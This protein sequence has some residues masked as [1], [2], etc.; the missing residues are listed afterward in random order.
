MNTNEILG[1]VQ[2]AVTSSDFTEPG[3]YLMPK[4]MQAFYTYLRN[5]RNPLLNQ[6]RMHKMV[7]KR[8]D[9]DKLHLS[10]PITRKAVENQAVAYHAEPQFGRTVRLNAEKL[11]A[12]W[13]K[14]RDTDFQQI[15]MGALQA[16]IMDKMM[17]RF[18]ADLELLAVQ[19]AATATTF[20]NQD[21][22]M[23]YLLRSNDGWDYLTDECHSVDAAGAYPNM[24]LFFDAFLRMPQHLQMDPGLKWIWNPRVRSHLAKHLS[25]RQDAVGAA[26]LVGGLQNPHG[27]PFIDASSIPINKSITGMA[28]ATAATARSK[29]PGT[30]Y[31]Y[32]TGANQN[33]ELYINVDGAGAGSLINL[34]LE[35]QSGVTKGPLTAQQVAN[36]INLVKGNIAK[37][38][39][40]GHVLITSPTTGAS[41]TLAF[42]GNAAT[43][44]LF[45]DDNSGFSYQAG[46]AAASGVYTN[47]SFIWLANP[48][49][50]VYGV[51]DR[52]RLSSFYAQA[53]DLDQVVMYAF[54]DFAVEEPDSIVK[55]KNVRV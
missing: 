47:G 51:L 49:N 27:I 29:T 17:G 20:D 25:A 52:V 43:T 42:T 16:T 26:G 50:F 4:Q 30:F 15:E 37:D 9:I 45:G 48:E 41:S 31:V 32:S 21:D 55:V 39:G 35:L 6:V 7:N 36:R 18:G 11:Q 44:G 38:D 33:N 3:G 1:A 10:R 8:E 5:P 54:A 2:Q 12:S 40:N 19:G 53:Y 23:G 46:A 22:D 24:D 28:V 34:A 14:T 13:E